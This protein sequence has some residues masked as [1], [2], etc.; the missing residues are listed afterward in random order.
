MF[1]VFFDMLNL[2][3][4]FEFLILGPVSQLVYIVENQT[5]PLVIKKKIKYMFS[6]VFLYVGLS[7]IIVCLLFSSYI[8]I[9]LLP[10]PPIKEPTETINGWQI[11]GNI[12]DKCHNVK[13][14]VKNKVWP[15]FAESVRWVLRIT[16]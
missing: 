1:F 9:V 7:Y 11:Y 13:L 8:S 6:T 2:T 3:A 5:R 15:S 16:E 14:W 4:Y 10:L 12:N